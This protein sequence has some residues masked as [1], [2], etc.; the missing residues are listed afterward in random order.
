MSVKTFLQTTLVKD[1]AL[2][3]SGIVSVRGNDSV[4]AA[5]VLL[6]QNG[7]TAI[8]V[9]DVKEDRYNSFLSFL[10]ICCHT[11]KVY[12]DSTIADKATAWKYATCTQVANMSKTASFQYL[13]D[14]DNL[15]AAMLKMVSLSNVRRLPVMSLHGDLVGLLSQSVVVN[16]LSQ[17]I[18]LFPIASLTIDDLNLGTLREVKHVTAHSTVK[19]AFDL[20]VENRIYGVPVVDNHNVVIGNISASDIQLIVTESDFNF[21]VF[22]SKIQD[23]LPQTHQKR[24]PICVH[25]T[26]TVSETFKLMSTE[27]IHRLF[28]TNPKTG[29]LQGLISPIDL[30]QTILDRSV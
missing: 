2:D 9:Y 4:L 14:T 25:S 7:V 18:D 29:Q 19:E 21:S 23:I 3:K 27:K 24:S 10:D 13:G 12:K 8:P 26:Q 5:L 15:Q 6:I 20:L 28:I 11:V 16:I 30:I 17:K 1:I 22:E